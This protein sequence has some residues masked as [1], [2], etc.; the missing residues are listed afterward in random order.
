MT[1]PPPN[2]DTLNQA[3]HLTLRYVWIIWFCWLLSPTQYD[4][5]VHLFSCFFPP[6]YPTFDPSDLL[7]KCPLTHLIDIHYSLQWPSGSHYL[8]GISSLPLYSLRSP[9]PI[10][11]NPAHSE[12]P[13]QREGTKNSSS[14][15]LAAITAPPLRLPSAQVP[16]S[17]VQ[18]LIILGH[19]PSLCWTCHHPSPTSFSLG[20]WLLQLWSPALEN[21]P[22]VALLK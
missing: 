20:M 3:A 2:S 13:E 10:S 1:L 18:L 19:K 7:S 4:Y 6:P 9:I 15:F 16:A 17:S 8:V 12:W 11:P 21:P 5:R 22:G 14:T